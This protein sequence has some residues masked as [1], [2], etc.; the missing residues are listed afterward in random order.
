MSN[1]DDIFDAPVSQ[2]EPAYQPDAPFDKD[3]WK[4]KK[5]AE[6]AEAYEM[7]NAAAEK[8]ATDGGAFK[9]YLDTQSRFDRY[10]V[11][12]TLLIAE[13][14]PAATRLGDFDFWKEQGAFIKKNEKG[15]VILEPGDEYTRED[16]SIGVS[17]NVKKV[18]DVSQT[19]AR[20]KAQPAVNRDER[21]LIKA[22]INKSPVAIQSAEEL[23]NSNAGALYDPENQTITVRKGMEGADIFRSIA[24]ELAHAEFANGNPDYDRDGNAFK[25]YC[26][27]YMLCKKHSIDAKG[28]DFSRLPASLGEMDAQGI[29]GEL[30]QIRDTANE[31]SSRMS[32]VLEQG[33]SSRQQSYER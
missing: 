7:M 25:A 4:E 29:R 31:I 33:K 5:Q 21:T 1:F 17:Y 10:S 23:A 20:P 15:V 11:G 8:A 6:R 13:Q 32:K 26:V 12:N 19:T 30:S 14:R 2:Q 28:Y 24:N 3:A 18:F 16:G 27:S 22:L 9:L